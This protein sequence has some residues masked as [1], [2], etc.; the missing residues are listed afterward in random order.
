MKL[1]TAILIFGLSSVVGFSQSS[2]GLLESCI[3]KI[4]GIITEADSAYK[5]FE[6]KQGKDFYLQTEKLLLAELKKLA[7]LV[8]NK[9][10]FIAQAVP[11]SKL[12]QY[13]PGKTKI[14]GV[15]HANINGI[16]RVHEKIFR[17]PRF[18]IYNVKCFFVTIQCI[19]FQYQ[20]LL[21]RVE[22]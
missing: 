12:T 14:A 21:R 11:A 7:L 19:S 16:R 20:P 1:L 13:Q 2:N 15:K 17:C 18:C 9:S 8:Q 5:L 22:P 6:L 10:L 4:P 3:Y